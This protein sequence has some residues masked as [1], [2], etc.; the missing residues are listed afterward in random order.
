LVEATS[1]LL[2]Q[3]PEALRK[4]PVSRSGLRRRGQPN[5]KVVRQPTGDHSGGWHDD[6]NNT[7][8]WAA[9]VQAE[10]GGVE[11]ERPRGRRMRVLPTLQCEHPN[12]YVVGDA[13]LLPDE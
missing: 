9:G 7:I 10:D 8:I 13:A 12:I 2:A 3:F 6:P 11:V 4:A 5:A 1:H